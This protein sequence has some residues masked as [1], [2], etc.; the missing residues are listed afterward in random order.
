MKFVAFLK[1]LATYRTVIAIFVSMI[2]KILVAK[3]ILGSDS[4][5]QVNDI[6]TY[7][8]TVA[9]FIADGLGIFFRMKAI[10]PGMLT[11][12]YAAH[13]EWLKSGVDR[14]DTQSNGGGQSPVPASLPKT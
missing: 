1:N 14:R 8:L 3:Q 2:L 11:P 4:L 12:Q 13:Q 7:V 5:G 10:T 6:T 9:S